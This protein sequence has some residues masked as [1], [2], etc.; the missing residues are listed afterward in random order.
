MKPDFIDGIRVT[1]PTM[2]LLVMY[3][4]DVLPFILVELPFQQEDIL[5]NMAKHSSVLL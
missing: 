2:Q 3:L 1:Q 4:R 5:P